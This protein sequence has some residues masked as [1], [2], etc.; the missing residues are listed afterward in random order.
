M[1]RSKGGSHTWDNVVA[2]CRTC[3]A[4]KENRLLHETGL[5][6][7]RKPAQP[8]E[9]SWILAATGAVRAD[10]EPYLGLSSSLSA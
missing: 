7:H 4:R 5:T 8:R 1:P 2:A 9:R 10:W 6:L 3:N